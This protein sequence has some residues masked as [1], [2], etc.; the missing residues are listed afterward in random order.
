MLN[1]LCG[2]ILFALWEGITRRR[3]HP[4]VANVLINT[5]GA[6][7][8]ALV[9]FL[10]FRDSTITPRM[11]RAFNK[12]QRAEQQTSS[13]MPGAVQAA[14]NEKPPGAVEPGK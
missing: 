2:H 1:P 12:M 3:V 9:I 5:F 13:G 10:T 14:T 6:L 8:I 4:R 11:L 7:L